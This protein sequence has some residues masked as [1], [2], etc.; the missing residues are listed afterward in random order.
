MAAK[1]YPELR[2]ESPLEP[3]LDI[4]PGKMVFS[5]VANMEEPTYDPT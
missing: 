3:V 4:Q 1:V 2:C 5:K